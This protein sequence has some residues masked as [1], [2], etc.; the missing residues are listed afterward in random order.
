RL[1]AELELGD[2]VRFAGFVTE[3]EKR[4]LFRRTWV[5]ALTSPKEGWGISNM[6]AAACGTATVAS[7]SPGLRDSVRHGSTGFLAPHGQVD[8][9]TDLLERVLSDPS[10]RDRLGMQARAF[11]ELYSW[12]R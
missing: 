6:E 4:E 5:H 3:E 9:L 1:T 7:D 10:L 2:H 11:A 8:A 12:E